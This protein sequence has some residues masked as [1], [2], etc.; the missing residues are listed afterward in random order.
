MEDGIDNALWDLVEPCNSAEASKAGDLRAS[1]QAA[2]GKSEASRLLANT[3]ASVARGAD[4]HK[5]R[6]L[7]L[8]GHA[9][10]LK[11]G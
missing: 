2:F 8:N 10:K 4:G 6:M 3:R 5:F 1:L 9:L 7:R 11:V